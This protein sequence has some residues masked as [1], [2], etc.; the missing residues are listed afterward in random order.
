MQVISR[1]EARQQ[2]LEFYF[3]GKPCINGMIAER[4]VRSPCCRCEKC[5]ASRDSYAKERYAKDPQSQIEKSRKWQ[6]ENPERMKATTAIYR[7]KNK[8]TYAIR[9][10]EWYEKN[11][12]YACAYSKEYNLRQPEAQ[13]ARN[14]AR[15]R[16][17]KERVP[18]WFS[19]LD[20][21][22]IRECIRLCRDRLASTGIKWHVDHMI[23]LRAKVA[24]GLHIGSNL[25]VIPA[26]LNGWKKNKMEL[27]MPDEW[28]QRL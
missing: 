26:F 25:Q 10:K 19:E 7:E 9:R 20:D 27:T 24:S 2:G 11:R 13:L 5:V 14:A 23:P 4:R 16:A 22:C 12:G 28:L 15:N 21:F 6:K 1:K 17:E 8:E 3:T 18:G